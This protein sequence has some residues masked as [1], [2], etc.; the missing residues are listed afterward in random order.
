MLEVNGRRCIVNDSGQ[1]VL[2]TIGNLEPVSINTLQIVEINPFSRG[3][4]PNTNLI[5]CSG[6]IGFIIDNSIVIE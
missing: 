4:Y 2:N 1:V 3:D 6:Y 5:I